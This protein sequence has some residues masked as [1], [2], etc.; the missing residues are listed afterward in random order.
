METYYIYEIPGVKI[1]CTTNFERR[2]KGQSNKGKM[3]LLETHTDIDKA[4]ERERELQAEKGYKVE[5][6]GFKYMRNWI[7]NRS[8]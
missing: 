1:G 2:Q 3:I 6:K 4:D 7:F 8:K 5:Y